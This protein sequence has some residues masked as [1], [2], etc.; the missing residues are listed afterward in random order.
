VIDTHC[1]QL[2]KGGEAF[3]INS[4]TI[5]HVVEG[6]DGLEIYAINIKY[7]AETE[8]SKLLRNP[9]TP[10]FI[11]KIPTKSATNFRFSQASGQLVFSAYIYADGNITSVKEQDDAWESRGNSAFVYDSTYVRHWDTWQGNKRP[12][13]FS[14]RLSQNPNYE[15]IFGPNFTNLLKGT[16]HVRILHFSK[17]RPSN[18]H[19]DRAP[20]WNLSEGQ[21]IL[22]YRKPMSCTRPRTPNYLKPGIPNRML[23][24]GTLC[25]ILNTYAQP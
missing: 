5:A 7:E 12:A 19:V 25:H 2:A 22:M 3:W 15:W 24:F 11:G 17:G 16:D 9:L 6:D 10:A 8:G 1:I 13:L 4:R 23:D 21:M 20:Q 18:H 14:V